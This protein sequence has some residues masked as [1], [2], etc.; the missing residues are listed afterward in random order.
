MRNK[1]LF[2]NS[3]LYLLALL[4]VI[5]AIQHGVSWLHIVTF[6]LVAIVVLFDVWEVLHNGRKKH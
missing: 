3:P 4:N 1:K 5:Y 6:V 2:R